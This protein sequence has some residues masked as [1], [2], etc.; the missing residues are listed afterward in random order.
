MPRHQAFT[1]ALTAML[2]GAASAH[3]ET[4]AAPPNQCFSIDQ[5]QGWKSPDAKT[6]YI[7]VNI[8]KFYRLDL[9]QSCAELKY[10]DSHLITRTIGPDMV[11]TAL[12]W[13]LR[14]SIGATGISV[15]CI[16]K[17]MTLLTPQ[18]A[19]AIPQGSRP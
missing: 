4:P 9:A 14:V 17:T 10:P 13:N 1:A 3:A 16:V 11:C 12:D 19:A 6:I 2:A 18:E 7:R 15:P 8:S 5:F